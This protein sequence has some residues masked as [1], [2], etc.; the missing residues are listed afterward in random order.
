MDVS[1]PTVWHLVCALK[2]GV[3]FDAAVPDP[4][5]CWWLRGGQTKST[6][7]SGFGQD[8]SNRRKWTGKTCDLQFHG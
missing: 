4:D 6:Q 1:V 8:V 2:A 3:F 7:K 5:I